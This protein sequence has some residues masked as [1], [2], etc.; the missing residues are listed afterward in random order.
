MY[1][2]EVVGA[3]LRAISTLSNIFLF[4]AIIFIF[5]AILKGAIM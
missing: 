4:W 5:W 2:Y 1:M 3:I